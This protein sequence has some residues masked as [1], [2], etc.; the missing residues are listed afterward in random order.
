M[1]VG[2]SSSNS[3]RPETL[4]TSLSSFTLDN[5]NHYYYAKLDRQPHA[6]SLRLFDSTSNKCLFR[7]A[8]T[9]DQQ[10]IT[11]GQQSLL[12]CQITTTTTTTKTSK[13]RRTSTS[14][15]QQLLQPTTTKTQLLLAVITV[16]NSI[17]L[18]NPFSSSQQ[19]Q[20]ETIIPSPGPAHHLTAIVFNQ[21]SNHLWA[22]S[23]SSSNNNKHY[24]TTY[25]LTNT[26]SP[27]IIAQSP[28]PSPPA[29]A[30]QQEKFIH[31]AIHQSSSNT[32]AFLSSKTI[33]VFTSS[34]LPTPGGPQNLKFLPLLKTPLPG[35]LKPCRVLPLSP[36]SSSESEGQA[37]EVQFISYAPTTSE[38]TT[39]DRVVQ[40]HSL[41]L[42]TAQARLV[43]RL[44]LDSPIT[45]VAL[46]SR[47]REQREQEE[48][49][50]ATIDTNGKLYLSPLPPSSDSS[51]LTPSPNKKVAKTPILA[52]STTTQHEGAK[53][54]DVV[55]KRESGQVVVARSGAKVSFVT[56]TYR[57][58]DG[59][60]ISSLTVP[61][62]G[63]G[64]L[65][66][67]DVPEGTTMA[68]KRYSEH[69]SNSTTG[70][71]PPAGGE[72]DSSDDDEEEEEVGVPSTATNAKGTAGLTLAERVARLGVEADGR[73]KEE[74]EEEVDEEDES[75][76]EDEDDSSSSSFSSEDDDDEHSREPVRRVPS[77]S[78]ATTLLQ[79]L[80]S[81]DVPLLES[82]LAHHSES[83]IL[84]TVRRIPR[85]KLVL[86][87]LEELVERL[88]RRGGA[89]GG[90]GRGLVRWIPSLVHRLSTLHASLASRLVLYPQLLALEG[91]LELA[92]GQIDM[93]PFSAVV[94][95][96][97]VD[98]GGSGKKGG[99]KEGKRYVEG[100]S[101]D[102]DEDDE[103]E[104][105]GRDVEMD[106]E[107]SEEEEEGSV[108]DVV[109]A[110]DDDSE[111]DLDS[112]EEEEEEFGPSIKK[113]NGQGKKERGVRVEDLLE[114]EASEDDENE[115]D[116]DSDEEEDGSDEEDSD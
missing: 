88:A 97:K 69:S 5:N 13:K 66:S 43:S 61:L 52:Q 6:H 104:E 111:G 35:H 62:V 60:M 92:L 20:Q 101:D 110:S 55:F 98:K 96:G 18:L 82:C 81:T 3:I 100:E 95:V 17:I 59:E 115:E 4:S 86:V 76:S 44:S 49:L 14:E 67:D 68:A 11:N 50:L 75:D 26:S 42:V 24:L 78:L 19:Q 102:E 85:G 58:D 105:G 106:E 103:E 39:G 108:E 94:P 65:V 63:G 93:K 114:L 91:R 48:S 32:I 47:S 99:K 87:L 27:S 107:D 29:S 77:T 16:S 40:F 79:A 10:L 80:H 7:W 89:R 12:L 72:E 64:G 41:S 15:N 112:D 116:E 23:S 8:A 73:S 30:S 45:S 22:L 34:I 25:D 36:P 31:L 33:S 57:D 109:L 53:V 51:P 28:I 113:K 37:D 84:D 9:S 1:R 46:S 54:V 83:L 56:L 38:S 70:A 71:A 21:A 2:Q 74:E 90:R